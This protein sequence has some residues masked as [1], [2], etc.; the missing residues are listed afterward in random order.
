VDL[1]FNSSLGMNDLLAAKENS[2]FGSYSPTS[3]IQLID[4]SAQMRRRSRFDERVSTK[5]DDKG[6]PE[7]VG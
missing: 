1:W 2:N 5:K 6:L 3:I 7:P 4:N